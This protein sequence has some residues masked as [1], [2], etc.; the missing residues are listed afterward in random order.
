MEHKSYADKFLSESS[1]RFMWDYEWTEPTFFF[2]SIIIF[3]DIFSIGLLINFLFLPFFFCC[4]YNWQTLGING[5]SACMILIIWW[6]NKFVDMKRKIS[7]DHSLVMDLRFRD[8]ST[9]NHTRDKTNVFFITQKNMLENHLHISK[10]NNL[11]W[12]KNHQ[13]L[14]TFC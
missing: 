8:M 3:S 6:F 5:F 2:Y 1:M 14:F 11:N 12:N 4:C 9:Q 13:L 10:G 7:A